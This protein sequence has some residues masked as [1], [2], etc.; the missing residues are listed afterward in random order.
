M[1]NQEH[2]LRPRRAQIPEELL[3]SQVSR[4]R[5][6]PTAS[7]EVIRRLA[8]ATELS[9]RMLTLSSSKASANVPL[10]VPSDRR[11]QGPHPK[12]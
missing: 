11:L 6:G 5:Q 7:V 12:G 8:A 9:P 4:V 1:A 2:D 10:F 3:A